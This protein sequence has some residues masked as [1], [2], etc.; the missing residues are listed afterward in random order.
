MASTLTKAELSKELFARVGL[1]QREATQFL[2]FLF[3]NIA[4]TLASGE[5]VKLAR[6][7]KFCLKDKAARP[8]RNPKTKEEVTISARRVVTFSPSRILKKQLAESM[9]V[10]E[11][12][13]KTC[14]VST[15]E[16][17]S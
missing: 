14:Q 4:A 15:K 17:T 7:G 12:K 6:F 8:G 2:D 9:S 11:S 1:N 16:G 5:E 10:S 13:G 3:N